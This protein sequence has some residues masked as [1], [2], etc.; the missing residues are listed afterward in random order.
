MKPKPASSMQRAT[1][2]GARSMRA[3]SA[4][5]TSALPDRPGGR[6]VAV[7]GQRAAGAGGDQRGGGR[8]VERRAPAAGARGVHEVARAR[9]APAWPARASCRARPASSSTVSPFVRSAMRKAAICASEALP[10]MISASTVG[11]LLLGEV[12]ARRERVDGPGQDVVRASG[13]PTQGSSSAA[14]CRRR[15]APTRDGTGRPR[16]AARGGGWPSRRRRRWPRPRSSRARRLVDH[17]RVVAPHGQRRGQAG[18]DRAPVVLDRRRL[19]VDGHVAHDACRRRPAPSTGGPGRR[20]ASARRPRGSGA[21]TSSEMPAS[22]GVH[23]P[24]E[25]TTRSKPR[26]SSS[27]TVARSLRTTSSSHPS[28]PRYWTRL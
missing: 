7:L 13:G 10:A 4:S 3:P 16:P 6:A 18:E 2:A 9:T 5:R 27:S 12:V 20:R 26:A 28:S 11:R 8:D 22:L 25:T 24:G 15:S 17:E 14:A 21:S 19:A 23:G 1:A